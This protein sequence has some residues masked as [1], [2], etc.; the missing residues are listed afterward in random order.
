VETQAPVIRGEAAER[1][2]I[3]ELIG[4]GTSDFSGSPTNRRKNIKLGAER[5]HGTIVLSGEEFSMIKTLGPIDGEHGWLPELVIKGN[6]TLPEFGGGLCQIGTTAF[7]AAMN[8]GLLITERRNHS[9]RVRY[10]EPAGTDATIYDPSPDFKFK[11][12]T[13]YAILITTELQGD[14]VV[15]S[16]WGTEDGREAVIGKSVVTNI[17]APPPKKLIETTD[18]PVGQT[19]CTE[20]AHAGA[21]AK[22]DYTVTY[23]NGKTKKV[24]FTSVYRPWQA[25][26][27]VGVAALTPTVDP[28]AAAID[29]TG[30]NNLN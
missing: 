18:L 7:R 2:G 15:F 25:V 28:A 6:R 9:Y 14:I 17:T 5:V 11:N 13:P 8:T 16:V 22:V 24:T 23:G 27:L 3:R 12:D 1:L 21:T 19:K 26:C 20:T 29:Q 30:I 4:R 10:Y